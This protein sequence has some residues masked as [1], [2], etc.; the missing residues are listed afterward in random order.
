ML[1]AGGIV[2]G[3]RLQ[4]ELN[5]ESVKRPND[6]DAVTVSQVPENEVTLTS[7]DCVNVTVIS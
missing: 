7:Q 1:L 5:S 2:R 6:H 4:M 3:V